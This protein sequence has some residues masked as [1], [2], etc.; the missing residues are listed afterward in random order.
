MK[1]G[2][3]IFP[4][5]YAFHPAELGRAIEERGLES[6]WVAEH[7]HIPASRQT[8][9]PGGADLPQEY[10][11][12]MDPFVALTAVAV[13]T[14]KLK[15][16]TG[17]CLVVERDPIVLANEVASLDHISGGRF[18]F[19][20][21]GGWNREEMRNHGTDP[22]RRW[23]VLRERVLAMK[24][25]WTEDAAEFHG[26]HVDFDPI[27][28]WPKP[29]QKPHPPIWVGGNGPTTFDRVIEYG[30]GWVPIIGRAVPM[31][32][33]ESLAELR[34]R[35]EEAGRPPVPVSLFHV[36]RPDEEQLKR[37]GELGVERSILWLPPAAA[38]Q[39]LPRLDRYADL[40]TRLT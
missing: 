17:V 15:L 12:T 36:G 10:W 2:V 25:I 5:E 7:T 8:P 30:D 37:Y 24:K 27:W 26:E 35:A 38:D 14:T 22:R 28:S 23:E 3:S 4:T 32:L 29:I 16:A 18:L 34:R 21:G 13:A 11:H 33:E 1:L 19:G 6:L 20:I 9:W 39:V 40:A 31:P